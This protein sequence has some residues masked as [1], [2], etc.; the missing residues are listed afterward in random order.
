VQPSTVV[1]ENRSDVTDHLGP[2]DPAIVFGSFMADRLPT[3]LR[4]RSRGRLT[5]VR[6][7]RA[8]P[9]TRLEN[10]V[11]ARKRT[12]W[13]PWRVADVR[14]HL[15]FEGHEVRFQQFDADLV[16]FLEAMTVSDRGPVSDLGD[17]SP[18]T[19]E[20]R[21][22]FWNNRSRRL[23]RADLVNVRVNPMYSIGKRT[24]EEA[25]RRLADAVL[26][27]AGF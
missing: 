13:A 8:E 23:S 27:L 20:V 16:L 22:A 17:P 6:Y 25:M 24:W 4:E 14:M 21:A 19:Y 11:I 12:W 18:L 10:V 2:G 15:P 5:E 9:S 1:I 26:E 7:L 3:L